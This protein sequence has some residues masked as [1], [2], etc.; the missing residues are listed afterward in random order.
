MGIRLD[1][2]HDEVFAKIAKD[3]AA[4]ESAVLDY[5]DNRVSEIDI[6]FG[7]PETTHIERDIEVNKR[8]LEKSGFIEINRSFVPF[9]T[10]A[11]AET[12]VWISNLNTNESPFEP[13]TI[14]GQKRGISVGGHILNY[15]A[16]NIGQ[17][18]DR[19]L[20]LP[21]APNLPAFFPED[22]DM[23]MSFQPK[24]LVTHN[25]IVTDSA[26]EVSITERI[27][28]GAKKEIDKI[29]LNGV[30]TYY[31]MDE[32]S[33]VY[34]LNSAGRS[35]L[36]TNP[37]TLLVEKYQ[38]FTESF[39]GTFPFTKIY[40][41]NAIRRFVDLSTTKLFEIKTPLA[42][43]RATKVQLMNSNKQV[44]LENVT[45]T[46]Y[47]EVDG[48]LT[49]KT[50]TQPMLVTYTVN[51]I[52]T[53]GLANQTLTRT[54][55]SEVGFPKTTAPLV[56]GGDTYTYISDKGIKMFVDAAQ[57]YY[58]HP[59]RTYEL[60]ANGDKVTLTWTELQDQLAIDPQFMYQAMGDSTDP[61]EKTYYK[62]V[63]DEEFRTYLPLG[64]AKT[65]DTVQVIDNITG[66]S[67]T[68]TIHTITAETVSYYRV[69]TLVD[70]DTSLTIVE[71]D[72]NGLQLNPA[73]VPNVN[74]PVKITTANILTTTT[75]GMTVTLSAGKEF[76]YHHTVGTKYYK[77]T[78]GSIYY[79]D[80]VG[81]LYTPAQ[82][83]Q[84]I[85][86][87]IIKNIDTDTSVTTM[88]YGAKGLL[89]FMDDENLRTYVQDETKQQMQL[90][91][92]NGYRVF[93]KADGSKIYVVDSTKMVTID[94]EGNETVVTATYSEL[95]PVFETEEVTE[96]VLN[97]VHPVA[98]NIVQGNIVITR[99]G[100]GPLA[101]YTDYEVTAN[102]RLLKDLE[103]NEE[104]NIA[105]DTLY[106]KRVG[107]KDIIL[108]ME[109]VGTAGAGDIKGHWKN[110][111]GDIVMPERLTGNSFQW[112][113]GQLLPTN[114]QLA[115]NDVVRGDD[116]TYWR[117]TGPSLTYA[118]MG[119]NK[120]IRIDRGSVFWE[121][122]T[123]A[124]LEYERRGQNY[125]LFNLKTNDVIRFTVTRK[126]WQQH[127]VTG[128]MTI[129]QQKPYS[130]ERTA[131]Q[132]GHNLF[133]LNDS[134]FLLDD[135]PLVASYVLLVEI[136]RPYSTY[137]NNRANNFL[138]TLTGLQ[139]VA[140]NEDAAMIYGDDYFIS[141]CTLYL[142]SA[143]ID[144]NMVL[145]RI[146]APQA[147]L[148]INFKTTSPAQKVTV[149]FEIIKNKFDIVV[150]E[151]LAGHEYTWIMGE[152]LPEGKVL[153]TGDVV[154]DKQNVK[155]YKF[156]GATKGTSTIVNG[157][158]VFTP[159]LRQSLLRQ[160]DDVQKEILRQYHKIPLNLNPGEYWDA[161]N[162]IWAKE[163]KV[164]SD[165]AGVM[166][167]Y[168]TTVDGKN[169]LK[170]TDAKVVDYLNL[171]K[172]KM[173]E[174]A[175]DVLNDA[176]VDAFEQ[177]DI[178]TAA[179]KTAI[180]SV[181]NTNLNQFVLKTV[182]LDEDGEPVLDE[183]ANKIYD[184]SYT[185]AFMVE[186]RYNTTTKQNEFITR[187]IGGV[188]TVL[189]G[190]WQ[191]ITAPK[192]GY[193]RFGKTFTI[194]NT[195]ETDEIF[196][197]LLDTGAETFTSNSFKSIGGQ[198]TFAIDFN[199]EEEN[200]K[201]IPFEVIHHHIKWDE[202]VDYIQEGQQVTLTMI[203]T[204]GQNV[205][206]RRNDVFDMIDIV[207]L[208]RKDLVFVE[209]W[210]EDVSETGFIFPFG[211]VQYQGNLADDI[212]TEVF[213]H[214]FYD[215]ISGERAEIP[216]GA[217]SYCQAYQ[218]G[219][220]VYNYYAGT[221]FDPA[222]E[223]EKKF[224]D[225]TFVPD[226]TIGKGWKLSNLNE[227]DRA[228]I[229]KNAD[230]NLYY[231]GET[232]VQIRYRTR[233]VGMNLFKNYFKGTSD[234]M[235]E[236]LRF[237][238]KSPVTSRIVT[239][240][241]GEYTTADGRD[242]AGQPI[243]ETIQQ[244]AGANL[245]ISSSPNSLLY[246][247]G[248]LFDDALFTVEEPTHLSHNGYVHAIPVAI[249]NRRNQGVYHPE[250]NPNGT[251]FF[252]NG[253]NVSEDKEDFRDDITG[254]TLVDEHGATLQ[255]SSVGRDRKAK[256]KVMLNW[257]FS[258]D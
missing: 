161:F 4:R 32:D 215:T 155:F 138:L 133:I 233:V 177:T 57:I 140:K 27:T 63:Y 69:D 247:Q 222:T 59:F 232:L 145:E 195:K 212:A 109:K 119:T 66:T 72:D 239:R 14:D 126:V 28:D 105:G 147:E 246:K 206:I 96:Y 39:G 207:V 60:D 7:L 227:Q 203:N 76:Y 120:T 117:Y 149:P 225:S 187:N 153:A 143:S 137:K 36:Q 3:I 154:F 256:F 52:S 19:M 185:R 94:S 230:H 148:Q 258:P 166:L 58:Y 30:L 170:T 38:R 29:N 199:I 163:A 211:N 102:L 248:K 124:E 253:I 142:N 77:K 44:Y 196:V 65:S 175:E 189:T 13:R 240:K 35:Y 10:G 188:E 97:L 144:D 202:G 249:V 160:T 164:L 24:K 228:A 250:Y 162:V 125:E 55:V 25:K 62:L 81:N 204:V 5:L 80:S 74:R 151:T 111:T 180:K 157:Q 130:L 181:L 238:G 114:K 236:G 156:I 216:D 132:D 99:N 8:N 48:V 43:N 85:F 116:V 190:Q 221:S 169:V 82:D 168:F 172:K 200:G 244:F 123:V 107:K 41:A 46:R 193:Y 252:I 79:V 108:R 219:N 245:I 171:A 89:F 11:Q 179:A 106:I 113:E 37:N 182:R 42:G 78:N 146:Q 167:E 152:D 174:D 234:Y 18:I 83:V 93:T 231:D 51:N 75:A 31:Y 90:T 67:V 112:S 2:L 34:F 134:Y 241:I 33:I 17:T 101:K 26:I 158:T 229:F 243:T 205:I 235:S 178:M 104:R 22:N 23:V 92:E 61:N 223:A 73:H 50:I 88:F 84:S 91:D 150:P 45:V 198:M 103:Y 192:V 183:D 54:V 95:T 186:T 217:K 87:G 68:R 257:L 100:S 98:F 226:A 194:L 165:A 121:N 128:E 12:G 237:Q 6:V 129:V 16:G 209:V 191:D 139:T 71:L 213:D 224:I 255:T 40:D 136:I 86:K 9:R 208:E 254:F 1:Q 70:G 56:D 201:E 118:E 210:H 184:Y 21:I 110:N 127:P 197:R 49:E 53:K 141:D 115:Y 122:V 159:T 251:G 173:I 47:E 218:K 176:A 135:N 20:K 64:S 220:T 214:K 242:K 131:L 15:T